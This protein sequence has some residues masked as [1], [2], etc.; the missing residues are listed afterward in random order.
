[1]PFYCL[2]RLTPAVDGV[3]PHDAA[4]R[5]V[6]FGIRYL[7]FGAVRSGE[8]RDGGRVGVCDPLPDTVVPVVRPRAHS[9]TAG[10]WLALPSRDS[11]VLVIDGASKTTS[12][13]SDRCPL[14]HTIDQQSQQR[15]PDV[16]ALRW[17]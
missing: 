9:L 13:R 6:A 2:D 4:I 16:H 7:G 5:G 17:R 3:C 15:R 1:M 12:G 14:G 8:L 11:G 10:A